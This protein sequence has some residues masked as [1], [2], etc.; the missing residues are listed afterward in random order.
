MRRGLRRER[1][2]VHNLH[3]ALRVE[4]H[5][6][7][8]RFRAKQVVEAVGS[9]GSVVTAFAKAGI[10]QTILD[11][12]TEVGPLL[13]AFQEKAERTGSSPELMSYVSNLSA[14][15]RSRYQ[16]EPQQVPTSAT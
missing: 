3:F 16:S 1:E 12:G 4:T 8:V 7:T 6:A 2:S 15:W 5:L 13:A 14:A 10:Y 9:F 11:E